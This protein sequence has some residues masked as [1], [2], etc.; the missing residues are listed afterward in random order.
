MNIVVGYTPTPEGVAAVDHA[1]ATAT[2]GQD[3]LHVVNSGERGNDSGPGFAEAADWDALD[4]RLSGL[5]FEHEMHQP[6][7]AQSAA[8]EILKVATAVPADIIIIGIRKRSP[9]GKL[10]L[11]SISQQVILEA[12]C[13][14][15]AV[16][17]P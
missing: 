15:V 2:A 6:E 12:E 5:G 7:L 3:T 9:V 11:G 4:A 1:V 17:R 8:D 16:K 13:P 10:F 14:V